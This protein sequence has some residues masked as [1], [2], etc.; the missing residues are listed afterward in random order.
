MKE[1]NIGSDIQRIKILLVLIE[2][3]I[4]ALMQLS[5]VIWYIKPYS[6][7][8]YIAASS[9]CST[10]PLS[11]ILTKCLK[12]IEKQHRIMCKRYHTDHGINPMWIINNSNEVHIA[13]AKLNRRKACKHIRTYDFSTLYTSIPHKLLKRQLAWV[14][15]SAFKSSKK[16]YISVYSTTA[17]WTFKI[18]HIWIVIK[19]L[20][21]SIPSGIRC[22][23]W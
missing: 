16:D 12:L 19:W 7:Q 23:E 20:E 9:C 17:R 18:R 22:G 8:R 6:K 15:R 11:A 5:N 21:L 10:K 2:R 13:I 14:I 1:L 3:V 4:K